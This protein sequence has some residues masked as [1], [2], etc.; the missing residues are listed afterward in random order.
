MTAVE[1]T[2]AAEPRRPAANPRTR[3][4]AAWGFVAP[5]L[6][7]IAVFFA[8]PVFAALLLSLTDFDIYALADLRNLRFVGLDNYVNL[9]SNPLFWGAM[10]NT[11]LFALI[12]VPASI[13]ASLAAALLL[14]AR[15][16]RWRPVWR[17]AFFAPFVTT[18]VATAVLW[19]YLLH[20]RYGLINWALTGVGLPAV[21]WLGSPA[22][23]I[24]AILIFVVWKTFGYNMLIFLAVLQTVPDELHEAARIDGAGAWTRFRHVTLPAIAPTLLLVSIISVAS[25]FQLFAEP[26]VM[27]QGGP[28]QST[29]TV[30]YFMYEEGFKWWNLGSASAVAFILFLCI[31]AITL[32]QLAVAGRLGAY[33]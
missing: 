29:V 24:P 31:L 7:A 15:I 4:R 9:F 32:I 10:K 21:D 30:L 17:V 25:F 3:S 33:E 8:V 23:S 5:A 18:L 6:I 16:I 26:Y 28:A 2:I 12:G 13:A 14:N 22:T 1:A 11:G 19:N 27:T 20:T